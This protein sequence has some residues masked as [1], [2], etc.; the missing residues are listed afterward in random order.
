[1]LPVMMV[2]LCAALRVVPHPPNFAP[3]GATAVLAGRTLR[4]WS[5]MAVVVAAM[6]LGDVILAWV[7]GYPTVS[8]VT[9][10]VYGGFLMQ[11]FLGYRWRSRKGGAM[12]AAGLGAMAFFT[13]SNLGV[14]LGGAWYSHTTAGLARCFAAALPFF[15]ATI[16]GDLVW[17]VVLSLVYRSLAKR[18]ENR[19]YWLSVPTRDLAVI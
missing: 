4:P 17:T 2:M 11:A 8:A 1:M 12:A 5:A 13:L 7:N 10:F 15:P 9:P 14:W 18:L 3:V 16:A 19:P 6:F